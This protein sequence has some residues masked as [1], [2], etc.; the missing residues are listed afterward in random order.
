MRALLAICGAALL[1]ASCTNDFGAFSFGDGGESSPQEAGVSPKEG[2]VD[3]AS[4]D[5]DT[6]SSAG[7][8]DAGMDSGG[9]DPGGGRDGGPGEAGLAGRGDAAMD[10]GEAGDNAE[11]GRDSDTGRQ[12]A[13]TPGEAACRAA[14]E[15]LVPAGRD[16]CDDCGC[17]VCSVEVVSCLQSGDTNEDALC[18]CVVQCALESACKVWDCYC[19]STSCDASSQD[20]DGPCVSEMNAAA[21]GHKTE[22]MLIWQSGDEKEPLVRALDAVGCLAGRHVNSPGGASRGA[23]ESECL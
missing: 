3:D 8:S 19:S 17:S 4:A 16:G 22:V 7:S 5:A 14:F 11:A 20:G 21:G 1:C 10:S 2:A 6:G 18:S 15:P 13:G 23:C 12:D 9:S